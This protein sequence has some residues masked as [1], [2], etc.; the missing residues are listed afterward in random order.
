MRSGGHTG[1]VLAGELDGPLAGR[2]QPGNSAQGGGL[3]GAVAADQGHH[4]AGAHVEGDALEH[5]QT[6]IPGLDAF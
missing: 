3:A 4:L 5:R 2:Q 6:A 1:E